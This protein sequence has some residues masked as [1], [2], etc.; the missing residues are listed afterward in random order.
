MYRLRCLFYGC[1]LEA[2]VWSLGH[3][4]CL[5]ALY[6]WWRNGGALII[7][8][9]ESTA[10]APHFMWTEKLHP[11]QRIKHVQPKRRVFGKRALLHM[12]R[13]EIVVMDE[14]VAQRDARIER[15]RRAQ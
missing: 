12:L 13:H 3:G 11:E 1:T 6:W 15:E 5:R 4:N 8:R 9:S 10:W 7:Q 2:Y 14:T